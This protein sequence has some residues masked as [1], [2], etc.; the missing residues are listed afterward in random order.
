MSTRSKENKKIKREDTGTGKKRTKRTAKEIAV[1]V[2]SIIV[3]ITMLLPSFTYMFAQDNTSSFPTSFENAQEMYEPVVETYQK[4]VDKNA[5]NTEAWYN[6]GMAYYVWAQYANMWAS[7][8][9]QE[10][11]VKELY[12]KGGDA[13]ATYLEKVGS[14]DTDEAKEAA[15][16]QALCLF[17]SGD[18]EAALSKLQTV[19]DETNFASAWSN[20]G[21]IYES[22]D[23]TTKA[24]EAYNKAIEADPDDEASQKTYAESRLSALETEEAEA[25]AAAEDGEASEASGETSAG[26]TSEDGASVEVTTVEEP[27]A[28]TTQE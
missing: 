6:L 1:I 26:A 20:I 10:A 4:K 9:E 16:Q 11:E 13:L 22:L 19:A 14:L 3:V 27:E 2:V 24:K 18:S 21:M 17:Y 25:A 12:S 28:T 15:V 23:D 5:D 8:D 7:G